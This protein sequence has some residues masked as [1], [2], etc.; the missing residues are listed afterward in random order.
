M[1]KKIFYH[2]T[3]SG[4]VVY[5]ANYLKYLEEARVEFMEQRGVFVK[6]LFGQ[7]TIFVVA[8]Q[9]IDYKSPAF[10]G[11]ILEVSSRLAGMH[12]AKLEFEHHIEN[13]DGKTV[14]VAKSILVCVDKNLK[15]K[16]VPEDIRRK[17]EG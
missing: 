14:S 6:E 16:P 15:P 13:Q 12:A 1:K 5:Y 9:E 2:D 3:D 7:G 10:Y 4:G 17:L 11:D 8:R